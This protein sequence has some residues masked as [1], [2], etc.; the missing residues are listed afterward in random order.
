MGLKKQL[1]KARENGA[2]IHRSG[3]YAAYVAVYEEAI[4][5]HARILSR[6]GVPAYKLVSVLSGSRGAKGT[7]QV[8]IGGPEGVAA[9][10]PFSHT[11]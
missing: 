1:F 8:V 10:E 9:N 5:V 2:L 6:P 4:Q 7:V 3:V 11:G